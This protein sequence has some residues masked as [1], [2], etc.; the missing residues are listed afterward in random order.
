M[1]VIRCRSSGWIVTQQLDMKNWRSQGHHKLLD[2]LLLTPI[3]L[4]QITMAIPPV[5]F[6]GHKHSRFMF[7]KRQTSQR[8]SVCAF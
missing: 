8:S 5:R 2:P 7:I 4:C 1:L 6:T 3:I